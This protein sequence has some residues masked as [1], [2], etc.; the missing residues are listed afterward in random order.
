MWEAQCSALEK[1]ISAKSLIEFNVKRS[2]FFLHIAEQAAELS[3]SS[4]SWLLWILLVT[5]LQVCRKEASP[6]CLCGQASVAKK[7]GNELVEESPAFSSTPSL[8]PSAS[9]TGLCGNSDFTFWG[10]RLS[11]SV[12]PSHPGITEE[13]LLE[14]ACYFFSEKWPP[15]GRVSLWIISKA[16]H[17]YDNY[18]T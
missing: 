5:L 14:P 2:T 17:C 12:C 8:G 11:L 4:L 9:K 3:E 18:V 1:T 15:L 13:D 10:F 7:Q 16:S 6:G